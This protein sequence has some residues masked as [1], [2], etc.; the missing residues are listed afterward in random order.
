MGFET[1]KGYVKDQSAKLLKAGEQPHSTGEGH[2]QAQAGPKAMR[3][4]MS[5][6]LTA[7]QRTKGSVTPRKVYSTTL[8]LF[9]G[10]HKQNSVFCTVTGSGIPTSSRV[11]TAPIEERPDP[12]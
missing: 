12:R 4:P 2:M 6:S 8:P 3:W 1:S 7:N 11:V 10:C 9:L 5:P